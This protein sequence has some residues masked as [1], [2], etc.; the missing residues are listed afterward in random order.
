MD[1]AG[2]TDSDSTRR[3]G[4]AMA[5]RNEAIDV[6]VIIKA[7]NEEKHIGRCI[8]LAL[9]SSSGLSC[10]VIVADSLSTDRTVNIA[11][12]H[13]V[14]IV[15]LADAE[16]RSCGVGPQ[17]GYQYARGRYIYV[18]DADMDL[19]PGFIPQAVKVMQAEVDVAGVA[20]M[21][22][23][24]GGNSYEY[25]SR[26]KRPGLWA[27]IGEKSWL[28]MG[29]LYR[30]EAIESAGYLS[31]RNLHSLEEQE[32][33]LRLNHLGWRMLR[34]DIPAVCHHGHTTGTLAL[35]AARW[36]SRYSDGPGEALRAALG[37]PYFWQVLSAQRKFVI[38]TMLWVSWLISL[39]LVSLSTMPV[40]LSSLLLLTILAKN[41]VAKRSLG[42]AVTGFLIW[43]VRGAAL[44]RG[45]LRGQLDPR[46]AIPAKVIRKQDVPIRVAAPR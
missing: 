2:R 27:G 34:L 19:F 31:N 40:I 18:L 15:Q 39:V 11:A 20:G 30:R 41:I 4:N 32:L 24:L 16:D 21:V 26:K 7:L 5:A 28:V 13:P 22:E 6:T 36:K 12:R 17:L 33:G 35:L 3:A 38:M 10:E 8:E 45:A 1:T 14:T 25:E 43:P 44:L 23:E 42:P 46:T 9:E 37:R 29:G